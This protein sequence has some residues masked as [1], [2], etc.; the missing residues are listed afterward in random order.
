MKPFLQPS[1]ERLDRW[2]DQNPTR[3]E[4]Y[5]AAHPEVADRYE[6]SHELGDRARNA[7]AAAVDAPI[8]LAAR[9]RARL[10]DANDTSFAAVGLDLMGLGLAAAR[11]L[12][13]AGPPVDA[14]PN[15][16]PTDERTR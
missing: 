3:F 5:L 13:D 2:L 9:L 11:T 6:H 12:L 8:D 7:L 14:R 16:P 15:E 4:R 1:V 10:A